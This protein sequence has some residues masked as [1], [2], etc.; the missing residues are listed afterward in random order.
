MPGVEIVPVTD[1][2]LLSRFIRLPERL[3]ATDPAYIAPLHMERA[4]ALNRGK[5]PLFGHAEA[6]YW[7]AV[8][9][10]R[11][12]GRISAQID[13]LAL[14]LRPDEPGLFGLLAA[15]DDAEVFTALLDTA[16]DWLRAR[17]MKAMRGPF[18]LNINEETGL[19]VDGFSAP[20]M[21]MMPHDLP[22]VAGQVEKRGLVKV[23][24][25]LAYLYDIRVE[26]PDAVRR[27][28]AR[29]LPPGL[30]VRRL[31]LKR[32]KE[33]I[34]NVTAIF[35]DAWSQN[36]GFV[37]LTEAETDYLAKA[38]KPLLHPRLTSLVE[39]DG[40]P[41]AFMI[42]LP[43]LNEA[44]KGLKGRL[45]PLGWV[46][47]LWR[48]K[49]AGVKTARVPLMGVRRAAARDMI[50]GLL[51]Y[52]MIDQVR[53]EGLAMGYTHIELSWILEDNL[54]MRRMIEGL[55]A[56]PYKTYRIYEKPI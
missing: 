32:I 8:R 17:G 1:K 39:R 11:D 6:Q 34:R 40:E 31:D 21:L 29:E 35:N 9:E 37:P 47:L 43:N 22:Y 25:V 44:I 18:S 51:P 49:V 30:K 19:L 26:L 5:N 33:E 36:W 28:L 15:E 16:A 23:K 38:L 41:V 53:R 42:A 48:L 27:L 20:P 52:L 3:H 7:L 13:R 24:D 46:R 12:V 10:G 14:K 45:L 55:R 2:R 4:E 56:A 50:G 54:P